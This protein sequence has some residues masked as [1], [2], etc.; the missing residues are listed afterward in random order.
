MGDV[1][2]RTLKSPVMGSETIMI[3]QVLVFEVRWKCN[4][5]WLTCLESRH[6]CQH[7]PCFYISVVSRIWLLLLG[8]CWDKAPTSIVSF[9]L[10]LPFSKDLFMWVNVRFLLARC[11]PCGWGEAWRLDTVTDHLKTASASSLPVWASFREQWLWWV[12]ESQREDLKISH[13][14]LV[15]NLKINGSERWMRY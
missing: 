7:F 14:H 12:R 5:V 15:K 11:P 8:Q 10:S 13:S 6:D 4:K 2:R 9:F 3:N 1:T